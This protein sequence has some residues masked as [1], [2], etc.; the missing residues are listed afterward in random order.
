MNTP[1]VYGVA[2]EG[3]Y[4]TDREKETFRLTMNFE[5]GLNTIIISPRRWGKTSL[6]NKVAEQMKNH[7]EIRIVRMDAFSVRTPEDFYRMFA[8]EIIKQTATRVE[9]WM[10]NAKRFL[11][12]LVPVVTMSA[13]PLNPVSFSLKSVVSNYGEEAL[14][15][16]ERIA[17]EKNIHIIICIDE[18]QQIGELNDSV[19]FQK[20]LRSV[21][22]HQHSVSYCLY[23]SKR[24]LLMNMF[25][26]RSYPFYKF[27]DMIFLERIPI[28]YWYEY[29]QKRFE[30][31]GKNISS[32]IID[33]IYAYVDGNSSY[34][35]QLSWLVWARTTN[36]VN[37]EILAD[38]Q[39]DLLNQNHALFMEQMNG[40][41]QYQIRFVRAV[42]DGK[43]L[44]INRKDTI[45]EYELGSSANI[46]TIKKALQK[47]E[48]VEIEGKDIHFS[49][50]IFIHW[51]HRN[52]HF[53]S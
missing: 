32:E 22:Q 21:W 10:E 5:N 46:A 39:Q 9:E 13:D 15:L 43:A 18:F 26:S 1:F 7:S 40:L 51:L 27:G 14:T 30:Q 12:S 19:T 31:A 53:L 16:P 37:E 38:A 23:G 11:S 52:S 36:E 41:T 28:Q 48:L 47:K 6:V 25:G 3:M 33:Q 20:K 4:F 45:E 24:H 8:T 42:M 44:E 17:K 49:D 34:V 29:I 50:P 35:Q 2:A